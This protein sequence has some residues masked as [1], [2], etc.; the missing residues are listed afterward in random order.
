MC[1]EPVCDFLPEFG[2]FTV[3]EGDLG[4][5]LA[6]S[7]AFCATPTLL[8]QS[9]CFNQVCSRERPSLRSASGV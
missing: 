3:N 2:E 6:A 5:E 7:I 4:G 1:K 9:R 8:R